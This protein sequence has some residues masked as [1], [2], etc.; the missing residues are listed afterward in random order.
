MQ[1]VEQIG[2]GI[3]CMQYVKNNNYKFIETIGASKWTRC[4]GCRSDVSGEQ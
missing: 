1:F 3:C 4:V 2:L